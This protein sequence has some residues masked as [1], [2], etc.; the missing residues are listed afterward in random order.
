MIVRISARLLKKALRFTD[1]R[2]KLEGELLAG[3]DVVK[4]AAWEVGRDPAFLAEAAYVHESMCLAEG[5]AIALPLVT[6]DKWPMAKHRQEIMVRCPVQRPL[7]WLNH[8]PICGQLPVWH[9][10]HGRHESSGPSEVLHV[11]VDYS[12]PAH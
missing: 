6:E 5:F 4:C 12:L 2:A 8:R 1:E 11:P 7:S 10:Q 9:L 3:M